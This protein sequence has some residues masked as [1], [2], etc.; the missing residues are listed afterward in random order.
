VNE[1]AEHNHALNVDLVLHQILKRLDALESHRKWEAKLNEIQA[2]R[3]DEDLKHEP[4]EMRAEIERRV[5]DMMKELN[6]N[7]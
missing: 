6:A 3:E 4:P 5:N 1:M 2:R 7:G